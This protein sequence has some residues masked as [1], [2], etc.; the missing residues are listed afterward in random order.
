MLKDWKNPFIV[1][2]GLVIISG[3]LYICFPNNP[4]I[5]FMGIGAYFTI[6]ARFFYKHKPVVQIEIQTEGKVVDTI[7]NQEKFRTRFKMVNFSNLSS[8]AYVDLNLIADGEKIDLGP[9]Y[10]GKL[11]WDLYPGKGINGHINVSRG[12]FEKV[13]SKWKEMR[14]NNL[15]TLKVKVR[16]PGI[17]RFIKSYPVENWYFNFTKNKWYNLEMG[18]MA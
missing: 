2:I 5:I 1:V 8:K 16:N 10:S 13:E 7:D 15:L 6:I 12:T 9:K 3:V 14:D 4:K 17:H 11:S 18:N